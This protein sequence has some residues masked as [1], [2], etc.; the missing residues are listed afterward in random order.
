MR[1][2]F[3]YDTGHVREGAYRIGEIDVVLPDIS[4]RLFIVPS[5]P[6]ACDLHL[7]NHDEPYAPDTM[8]A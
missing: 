2:I 7:G 8:D 4:H 1:L 3:A 6:S 5:K